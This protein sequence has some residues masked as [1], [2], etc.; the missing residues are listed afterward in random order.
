M[1]DLPQSNPH[2]S[3]IAESSLWMLMLACKPLSIVPRGWSND[4]RANIGK[5]AE[6]D[7]AVSG[8]TFLTPRECVL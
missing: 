1:H 3:V 2:S 5:E 8:S 7:K 4:T 6:W